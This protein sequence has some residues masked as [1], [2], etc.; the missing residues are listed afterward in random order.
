M[1]AVGTDGPRTGVAFAAIYRL[2]LRGQ[3]TRLRA[4]GLLVLGAVGIL[5]AAVTRNADDPVEAS[6][7]LIAEYG[8]AVVAPVCT[9]WVAS[10]LLGDL[11]EDRLLAY[12]WLK[13]VNRW[14]LP[15]A[16]VA[17]SL[18]IL[19][20]LTVAPLTVAAA[21]SGVG[22]LVGATVV[23]SLLALAAYSGLFVTVGVRFNRALWW[24]LL[25]ILVWENGIARISD[26][27]ARLAVRSYVVSI[28]G[29]AT[30]ADIALADR[31]AL[32][33]VVVPLAIA[34]AGVALSGWFLT[35]RDVD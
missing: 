14:V 27:T 12:L 29:R 8:L 17:A 19:V 32:A 20:P 11:I 28:I 31:S 13:P 23:A 15:A 30:D 1:T 33:S 34:A 22:A 25:Y 4:L 26:G 5:L 7:D 10:S 21:V 2:F 9:L 3:L 6:S 35:R 18:T 16:A 24:G